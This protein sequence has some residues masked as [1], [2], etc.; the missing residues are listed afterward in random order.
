[1][2]LFILVTNVIFGRC[3]D[4]LIR[5]TDYVHV[6][7]RASVTYPIFSFNRFLHSCEVTIRTYIKIKMDCPDFLVELPFSFWNSISSVLRCWRSRGKCLD[8]RAYYTPQK[9]NWLAPKQHRPCEALTSWKPWYGSISPTL[10]L[11]WRIWILLYKSRKW[12]AL[13]TQAELGLDVNS[14]I[15]QYEVT[16]RR[17]FKSSD[18]LISK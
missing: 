16:V 18:L 9:M 17:R 8:H 15:F 2:T 12:K 3:Y 7:N 13:H 14:E 4:W 6:C 11:F 5:M 10:S 1:M